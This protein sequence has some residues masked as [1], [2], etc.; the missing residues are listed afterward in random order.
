MSPVS[1]SSREPL[2][3]I[4]GLSGTALSGEERRFFADADPLGFILFARNC[5][6]P[7][8]VAR[9]VAELRATVGR[10]DAPVLIDQ[11]GGRVARLKP[12]HW[13]DYPAPARIAAL[14]GM[15]AR[16]AAWL[17]ARLIADDLAMLGIT[18]DCTPVLDLPVPGADPI[19]GD[20]AWGATPA[21][22]AALGLAVCDGLMAGGVLP[23]IKHIPGHGRGNVD[24]H[25]GLPVVDTARE[26]LDSTDFAAFRALA[27]MPWA[28][29]AHIL[30]TAID[31]QRPATSSPSLV[32]DVIRTSI[33]FDGVLV[34]D[35]LS[36]Q[37]LGGSL[38]ERAQGALAAG[39][40]LVLHCNGDMTEMS[41]I[42]ASIG[43]ISTAARRRIE[44]AEARR[45]APG[46]FDRFAAERRFDALMAG[47]G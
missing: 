20:R 8:Q 39:C 19:I 42:A 38:S 43:A 13:R 6:A 23:V 9:L 10:A 27:F 40:D 37:A 46:G 14:G 15:A 36:M 30:Y 11:E 44:A 28:M 3:V 21:R 26:T 5:E 35:D 16:K 17:G 4:F 18:V 7:A 32:H 22:A 33:G 24:S 31:A 47:Q 34:S 45:P 1:S 29:T 12:P 41:G 2:A 25:K